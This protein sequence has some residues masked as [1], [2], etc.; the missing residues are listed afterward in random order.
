MYNGRSIL[1]GLIIFIAVVTFPF[2]YGSGK[3][4]SAP[5]PQIDTPSI[6]ALEQKKC[7]EATAYMRSVHMHL[8]RDWRNHVVRSGKRVYVAED[9]KMYNMSLQNTCMS[10]HSNKSQ[11]CDRCH[12]Y[13]GV[14]PNCWSCHIEPKENEL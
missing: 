6:R 11:F 2:W 12:D 13:A 9:G 1:A 14:K 3:A 5:D 8:L 7:I 4:V 10:C